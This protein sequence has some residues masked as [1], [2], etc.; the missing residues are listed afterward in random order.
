[1][2]RTALYYRTFASNRSVLSRRLH[3]NSRF[4]LP[5]SQL[6]F[7]CSLPLSRDGISMYRLDTF[8][9]YIKR[10]REYPMLTLGNLC[11]L[12]RDTTALKVMGV[13]DVNE[14][15]RILCEKRLGKKTE[16]YRHWDVV[17]NI[18]QF[19]LIIVSL[20]VVSRVRQL[21]RWNEGGNLWSNHGT[22]LS[23]EQIE[24]F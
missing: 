13:G 15:E 11:F 21:L 18:Y 23:S 9:M 12:A 8:T 7:A 24:S 1:M 19:Q 17:K 5:S 6:Y 14:R 16:N 2:L 3:S 20:A 10:C 4:A 22:N